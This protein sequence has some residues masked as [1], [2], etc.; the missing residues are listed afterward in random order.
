MKK[1]CYTKNFKYDGSKLE[2]SKI[3][4]PLRPQYHIFEKPKVGSSAGWLFRTFMKI[5]VAYVE[6]SEKLF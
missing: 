5:K 4:D 6:K 2:G 1:L 3:P